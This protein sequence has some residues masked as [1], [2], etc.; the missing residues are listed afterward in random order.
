MSYNDYL[1]AWAV[2]IFASAGLIWTGFIWTRWIQ[3]AFLRR[4]VRMLATLTLLTPYQSYT[5]MDYL[6]PAWIILVFE[7]ATNGPDA[8][9]RAGIPLSITLGSGLLLTVIYSLFYKPS[10]PSVLENHNPGTKDRRD[11]GEET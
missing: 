9:L 1:T 11:N 7:S 2:Y 6:A 8:A 4:S 5:D 10:H 3:P